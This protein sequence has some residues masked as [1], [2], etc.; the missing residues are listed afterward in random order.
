[1]ITAQRFAR[2]RAPGR[3][4][5]GGSRWAGLLAACSLAIVLPA[6]SSPSPG[7]AT[8]ELAEELDGRTFV[9]T[10]VEEDGAS[11]PTVPE[12][13]VVL[14]FSA[15]S[16]RASGGCNTISGDYVID[17]EVLLVDGT[18]STEMACAPPL[19]AQDE[20]LITLLESSPVI[21]LDAATLTLA[22]TPYAVTM[23]DR[24]VA[25]PDLSITSTP[26]ELNG[27]ISGTGPEATVSTVPDGV[28]ASLQILPDEA[29][30]RAVV[31]TGCNRG[32]AGVVVG[33]TTVEFGPMAVTRMA[34]PPP[35]TSVENSVLAVLQGEVDYRI[36]DRTLTLL[37][38]ESGLT[39][40][41]GG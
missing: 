6:C 4:L 20:W 35:Q 36:E 28:T 27:L 9:A 23:T 33:P 22:A 40:R 21:T 37:G 17:G 16:L 26:W 24:E 14:G 3:A 31:A 1:M 5:R 13:Q 38:K 32:S 11:R 34:C 41:A 18:A 29:G 19:M 39:Y 2:R 25:E 7:A 12:S 8:S 30:H 15:G 10:A